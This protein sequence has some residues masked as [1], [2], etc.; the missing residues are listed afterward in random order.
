MGRA[1]AQ[2]AR[3]EEGDLDQRASPGR[4]AEKRAEDDIGKDRVQDDVH[5]PAKKALRIVDQDVMDVGPPVGQRSRLPPQLGHQVF[6]NVVRPVPVPDQHRN[7]RVGRDGDGDHDQRQAP[8][9]HVVAKENHHR[10][11]DDGEQPYSGRVQALRVLDAVGDR[12]TVQF[13]EFPLFREASGD[14]LRPFAGDLVDQADGFDLDQICQ[15]QRHRHCDERN[16]HEQT[17]RA[18]DRRPPGPVAPHGMFQRNDGH[19]QDEDQWI[20]RLVGE[21]S[22]PEVFRSCQIKRQIIQ[23]R[24][25][26]DRV[27]KSDDHQDEGQNASNP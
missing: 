2:I 25:T 17:E 18:S 7:D 23:P 24:N 22:N 9:L 20:E 12:Q 6:R 14:Q 26:G 15:A 13:G 8:D 4:N 11:A 3:P 10:P 27:H 5:K 1:A 19:H 16:V 21:F